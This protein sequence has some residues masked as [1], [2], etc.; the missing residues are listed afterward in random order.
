MDNA[1]IAPQEDFVNT[2]TIS[3][4]F[5]DL[6]PQFY[7]VPPKNTTKKDDSECLSVIYGHRRL[8][9]PAVFLFWYIKANNSCLFGIFIKTHPS[10]SPT[11]CQKIYRL[12]AP[13]HTAQ[14][15]V[16]LLF[17]SLGSSGAA[18]LRSAS[19][20]SAAPTNSSQKSSPY[21]FLI[22]LCS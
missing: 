4:Y 6:V 9:N 8:L 2:F 13:I 21:R 7:P 10:K 11:V 3:S 12:N 18:F 5:V 19:A 20:R 14:S 22:Y 15:G 17:L 16:L 1:I